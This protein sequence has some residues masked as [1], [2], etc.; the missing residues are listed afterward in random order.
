MFE[1]VDHRVEAKSGSGSQI[2]DMT[3]PGIRKFDLAMRSSCPSTSQLHEC[4][5][6]DSAAKI[7]SDSATQS[8]P[9]MQLAQANMDDELPAQPK[10]RFPVGPGKGY[11]P[12]TEPEPL[13]GQLQWPEPVESQDPR[14]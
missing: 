10:R 4:H 11:E 3:D 8:K 12:E 13:D 5:L 1:K 6:F 7:G 9:L 14:I 2:V